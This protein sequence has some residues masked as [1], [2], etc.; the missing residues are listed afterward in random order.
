MVF[1]KW[2]SKYEKPRPAERGRVIKEPDDFL[3][4]NARRLIKINNLSLLQV[5]EEFKNFNKQIERA[6]GNVSTKDPE[7]A[8]EQLVGLLAHVIIA[9]ELIETEHFSIEASGYKRFVKNQEI[10]REEEQSGVSTSKY[11]R[12]DSIQYYRAHTLEY[13]QK[14]RMLKKI[15]KIGE[16]QT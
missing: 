16:Y 3:S 4:E 9:Y 8:R 15:Y 5:V 10:G 7:Q 1:C 11:W 13:L 14:I 6:G 12:T 2:L